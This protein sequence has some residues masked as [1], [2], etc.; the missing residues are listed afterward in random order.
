VLERKLRGIALLATL[1]AI[2]TA[3]VACLPGRLVMH[4]EWSI[5][6]LF[7]AHD[8]REFSN[9]S[10]GGLV[11]V[12]HGCALVVLGVRL[13]RRPVID[14][15]WLY[16]AMAAMLELVDRG[17]EYVRWLRYSTHLTFAG[18]ALRAIEIGQLAVALVV[19]PLALV[20]GA[21]RDDVPRA[22]VQNYDRSRSASA[23]E[24]RSTK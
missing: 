8:S 21:S 16:V 4:H 11:G 3:I 9:V 12:L 1:L 20:L 10:A 2:A 6:D 17:V 22:R 23:P 7:D 24:E 19:L 5:F 18:E 13:W 15:A 14:R